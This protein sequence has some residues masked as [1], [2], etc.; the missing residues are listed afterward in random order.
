M[1]IPEIKLKRAKELVNT[2]RHIALATTNE[3][4]S[5]HNSPVRFLHDEKLEYIYWGSNME[6]LHSQNVLRTGQ[7]FGVLFDRIEHGGV[8]MKCESG[9]LLSG[10]GLEVGLEIINAER[11]KEGTAK[12]PLEY[13][14][15]DGVQKLWSA[16]IT[17]IWI[18]MPVR[19]E[20]GFILR[21]ERVELDRNILHKEI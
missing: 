6:A 9:H 4:G 17:N 21:D 20:N 18:N 1:E 8:Y 15:A 10:K 5:P 12:I 13:Y 14:S 16:K 7:L 11:E 2:S 3:D 19:D